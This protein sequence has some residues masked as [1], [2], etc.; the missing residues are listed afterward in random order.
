[1]A[2][3]YVNFLCCIKKLKELKGLK[4]LNILHEV[5]VFPFYDSTF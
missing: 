4:V 2:W 5:F 1:M 3:L